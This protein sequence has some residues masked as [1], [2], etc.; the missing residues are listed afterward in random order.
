MI[1]KSRDHEF[2]DGRKHYPI[3]ELQETIGHF[4]CRITTPDSPFGPHKHD[5][6]EFWYLLSGKALVSIDG[7]ET[8]VEEGDLVVLK[9]WTDHGLRSE[10]EA[11]WLCFG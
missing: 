6:E 5:G 9:P 11:V 3:E 10:S 2:V 7:D 1:I 4:V 8:E